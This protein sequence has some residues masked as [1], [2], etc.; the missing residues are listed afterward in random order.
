MQRNRNATLFQE[1]MKTK[2]GYE[3]VDDTPVSLPLSFF[4]YPPTS[5]VPLP[6]LP[7]SPPLSEN[8][9]VPV[10]SVGNCFLVRLL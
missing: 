1:N 7:S 10:N 8:K 2:S 4:E 5:L 9:T 3:K 6:L